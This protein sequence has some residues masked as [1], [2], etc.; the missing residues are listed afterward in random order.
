MLAI[1]WRRI[2]CVPDCYSCKL[3]RIVSLPVVLYEWETQPLTLREEC[4]LRVFQNR[5]LR[6]IIGRMRYGFW[7]YIFKRMFYVTFFHMC[8]S[9][10]VIKNENENENDG[11][12]NRGVEKTT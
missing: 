2:F 1:I 12:D 6:G 4:R 8:G 9:V 5:V 11:R 10:A 3:Y 7:V